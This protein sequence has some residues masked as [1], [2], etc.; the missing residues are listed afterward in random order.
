M[1]MLKRTRKF[2]GF[3]VHGSIFQRSGEPDIDGSVWSNILKDWIHIKL[4]VKTLEG[5]P[6]PLQLHRL[7][8]YHRRGY[9]VGI[10]RSTDDVAYLISA[11]EHWKQHPTLKPF[12]TSL[13]MLGVDDEYNIYY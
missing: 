9:C 12:S 5:K 3:A 10:V 2:D 4:E 6:T 8:V 13:D 7:R 11:W 1:D